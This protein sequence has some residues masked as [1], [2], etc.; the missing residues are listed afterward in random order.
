MSIQRAIFFRGYSGILFED[1]CEILY[2]GKAETVC[3]QR[4]AAVLFGKLFHSTVNAYQIDI[5]IYCYMK[6]VV[7]EFHQV[8][9]AQAAFFCD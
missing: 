5:V 1:S 4:Q 7:K 9:F 2:A 6:T 3:E 8:T